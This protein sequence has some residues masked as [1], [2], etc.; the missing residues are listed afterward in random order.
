MVIAVSTVAHQTSRPIAPS[1]EDS[2]DLPPFVGLV[3]DQIEV[4]HTEADATRALAHLSS[5]RFVGFDTESKPT[6][7]KGEESTGPHVVQFATL[8]RGYIFQVHRAEHRNALHTLLQSKQLVKVGFG[9]KSDR[10]QMQRKFGVPACALLDLTTYFKQLGHKNEV[11]VRSAVAMVMQQRFQKSKR[12]STTNWS[13]AELTDA[14][15][16]YAANDAHGAIRVLHAL[17]VE[18]RVL[19]IIGLDDKNP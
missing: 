11:G 16:L 10:G 7:H 8:D 9:L 14:Q 17:D 2:A 15:L 3:L 13:N 19:P 18:E 5:H 6:F 4:P 12:V 1:K